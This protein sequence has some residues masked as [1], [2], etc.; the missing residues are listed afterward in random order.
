MKNIGREN[1]GCGCGGCGS[2]CGNGRSDKG[3]ERHMNS[4]HMDLPDEEMAERLKYYKD[5]LM[6]EIKFIDKRIE[7]LR[8]EESGKS[9]K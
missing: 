1:R 7:E 4:F 5:D 9:N 8:T 6:E 3:A 2:C